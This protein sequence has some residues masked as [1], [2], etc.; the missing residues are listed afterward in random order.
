MPIDARRAAPKLPLVGR[1][2]HEHAAALVRRKAPIVE[3]V[4][5][6]RDQRAAELLRE[7]VVPDIRRAA[8]VVVLEDEEHVPLERVAHVGDEA[9]GHVGVGVDAR[10]RREPFGVRRQ[11]GRTGFPLQYQSRGRI[12]VSARLTVGLR[13]F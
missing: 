8:Q 13:D 3:I 5:I 6:H 4:A 2:D 9:G 10:P 12:R 11:L 1:L 7:L